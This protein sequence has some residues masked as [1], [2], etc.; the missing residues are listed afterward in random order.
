MK[1]DAL[2][3]NHLRDLNPEQL[4]AVR[5]AAGP[6]LILAGAG[7]GKTRVLTRRVA[8][9][10]LEH[11]ARPSSIL[12]V[13]FT[14]KAAQEM[15]HR[16]DSLLGSSA[17][18]LWVSTFHSAGL[19]ILRRHAIKL[20]Y[21]NDFVIYDDQDVR[22][23]LRAVIK[24][25][26]IDEKRHTPADFSRVIDRAKNA[27]ITPETYTN[28]YDSS[29]LFSL[30]HEVYTN[31]QTK[32]RSA[33]AMDFGDLLLNPLLLFKEH[34]T[35]L[36]QYQNELNY[37][38]VDEFQDTN[39]VQ[40]D[41][42]RMLAE[43]KR[44]LLVVGDDDQSIYAFRGATVRNILDFE[45]DFPGAAVFKLEQNYR[46]TSHIL[47]AAN[48]VISHNIE[49]KEKKLWT[50]NGEGEQPILKVL[51]D[52]QEEAQF[53]VE[54]IAQLASNQFELKDIAIFYRTHAQSRALEEAFIAAGIPYRIY[55]G[56]K[57]Y[58]RKE[59][60]DMIAYLRLIANTRD[61]Q[62]FMRIIN[63]PARG[64]GAQTL[65]TITDGQ[66]GSYYE[67]AKLISNT[68]S[69]RAKAVTEFV[70]LIEGLRA[71]AAESS[72]SDLIRSILKQT[73]YAERITASDQQSSD[74][75]KENLQ[76]LVA[77][78][79]S[80]EVQA[81]ST[82]E[83]LQLFLDRVALTSGGDQ[84]TSGSNDSKDA[85]TLMT[86][87][88]AKG[89]EFRV[90]FMVGFED[91]LLPHYR[92]LLD[93]I[94][95]CEER[96]L[97]YVGITRAQEKLFITRAER[98]GMFSAG[99]GFAATGGF[100]EVSRFG[101][102]LPETLLEKSRADGQDFLLG[103]YTFSQSEEK[104]FDEDDDKLFGGDDLIED[105]D[106]ATIRRFGKAKKN[107]PVAFKRAQAAA[108][109]LNTA[110]QLI[111]DSPANAALAAQLPRLQISQVTTGLKVVHPS[112][113]VG[114]IAEVHGEID[115]SPRKLRVDVRFNEYVET[116]RL[117]FEFAKLSIAEGI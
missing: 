59:I 64:I 73:Q 20:D 25:L 95:I 43:P 103:G 78:A 32:L 114:V 5:H 82:A 19:K 102:E 115:G 76:E 50:Q 44:N 40:Y 17:A 7:S 10:V 14:N 23:V 22:G 79:A 80:I 49:R 52:E 18:Q 105:S 51:N 12:A 70:S 106:G 26:G 112:Y 35:L 21:L 61:D 101:Y 89:L 11:R 93:P 111:S 99:E 71:A 6:V 72:L 92:T 107:K 62:A 60:K 1:T 8:N 90:V 46:S 87:H 88:L 36:Q 55:G 83:A 13:T 91:G 58:D 81:D 69:S 39:S 54:E 24:E 57:F 45:R 84:A 2:T 113:G 34:Q 38:L 33:N 98:R 94:E 31:Y 67:N 74:S 109:K 96:R 48:A 66:A 77:I 15:R 28:D 29:L 110:D 104:F 47:N 30:N 68:R 63:T 85:V 27:G 75:R 65:Q 116:K 41:L 16:L 9:L 108:P 53:V 4:A 56:L 3:S 37:I 97:C 117:I 86:F 42:I 100:R